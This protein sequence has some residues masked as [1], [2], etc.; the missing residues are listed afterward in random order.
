MKYFENDLPLKVTKV[1]VRGKIIYIILNTSDRWW[2]LWCAFAMTGR[3]SLIDTKYKKFAFRF[4]GKKLLKS[5]KTPTGLTF[6]Q[7]TTYYTAANNLIIPKFLNGQREFILYFDSIRGFSSI[8]LLNN[9]TQLTSKLSS[10]KYSFLQDYKNNLD[11]HT[12]ANILQ[13]YCRRN[14]SSVLLD[15]KIFTGIGN[16]ILAESLYKAKLSPF[17]KISSLNSDDINKLF[18]S[19][20]YVMKWSYL[21]QGGKNKNIMPDIKVP[22]KI[23]KFSVYRQKYDPK[24]NLVI[25]EKIPAGRT[26]HWVKKIQ[27]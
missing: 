4:K 16:Y 9:L 27:K 17:R 12:F 25:H 20:K 3:F 6:I 18:K 7:G 13:K 15:A 23:F 8:E 14:L 2:C 5:D 24:G 26:G 19:I 10:L 11:I 1:G 21:S 22:N